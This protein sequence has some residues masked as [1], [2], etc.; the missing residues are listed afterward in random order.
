[1]CPW[2]LSFA[3]L[4]LLWP[5]PQLPGVR[6]REAGGK[7]NSYG[8]ASQEKRNPALFILTL[9]TALCDTPS[10]SSVLTMCRAHRHF[11]EINTCSIS[12]VPDV[13]LSSL[14][15]LFH[16]F[17]TLNTFTSNRCYFSTSKPRSSPSLQTLIAAIYHTKAFLLPTFVGRASWVMIEVHAPNN[18]QL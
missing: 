12:W 3:S 13:L 1:M 6:K 10:L 11:Q 5:Q 18:F 17:L 8:S 2:S 7:W 15:I 4:P 16:L 9:P 14:H